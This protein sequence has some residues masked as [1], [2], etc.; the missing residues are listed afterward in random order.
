MIFHRAV[1][2]V[3]IIKLERKLQK[4]ALASDQAELE[5]DFDKARLLDN[6]YKNVLAE[7]QEAE[8][9]SKFAK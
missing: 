8:F 7:I 6:E 4:I 2:A 9:E 5:G 3:K 1:H